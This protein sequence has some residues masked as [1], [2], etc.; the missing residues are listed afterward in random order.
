MVFLHASRN[1]LAARARC[2]GADGLIAFTFDDTPQDINRWRNEPYWRE[3]FGDGPV[4]QRFLWTEFYE[5]V[6][7]KL[8]AFRT[9]R[10]PLIEGIHQI[11]TKVTGLS[12]L[13]DKFAAGTTGPLQDICPFTA[14]ATFNRSMTDANSK[15]IAAKNFRLLVVA[16]PVPN[17]RRAVSR[18]M[19][20]LN[21][22]W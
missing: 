19:A 6:A 21:S 7:E 3:R 14:M 9:D 13:Q 1:D 12:D 22:R 16:V 15:L 8:L 11:A 5:A 18:A 4:R 10:K 2:W 17:Q 20:P